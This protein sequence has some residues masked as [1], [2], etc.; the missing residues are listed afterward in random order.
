MMLP[1]T[2]RPAARA[3]YR[4]TLL[5]WRENLLKQRRQLMARHAVMERTNHPD[6]RD[7]GYLLE[8]NEEALANINRALRPLGVGP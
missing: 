4:D 7:Q 8:I 5:A 2:E 3:Y 6:K 1:K